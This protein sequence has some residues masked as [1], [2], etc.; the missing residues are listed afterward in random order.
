MGGQIGELVFIREHFTEGMTLSWDLRNKHKAWGWKPDCEKLSK[1][2]DFFGQLSLLKLFHLSNAST[3][4]NDYVS[5]RVC[6]Q[7]I[8]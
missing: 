5:W 1:E 4:E 6:G 2:Y 8:K 7:R 3:K